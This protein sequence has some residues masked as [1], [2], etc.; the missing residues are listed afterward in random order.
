MPISQEQPTNGAPTPSA[1]VSEPKLSGTSAIDIQP[2]NNSNSHGDSLG[3]LPKIE[4][5]GKQS[6]PGKELYSIHG[7]QVTF[8]FSEP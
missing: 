1:L 5:H 4:K 6:E 3:P 8:V 2:N 7:E